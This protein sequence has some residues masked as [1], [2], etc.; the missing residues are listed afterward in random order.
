MFHSNETLLIIDLNL[1]QFDINIE[2]T[3]IENIMLIIIFC[4]MYVYKVST[5]VLLSNN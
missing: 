3:I 2:T 4:H 5:T 1:D